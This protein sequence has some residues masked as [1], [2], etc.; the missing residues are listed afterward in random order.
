MENVKQMLETYFLK[1]NWAQSSSDKKYLKFNHIWNFYSFL[2]IILLT[3]ML[4]LVLDIIMAY[5]VC[6]GNNHA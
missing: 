5:D 6:L 3:Q 4:S 1:N 2:N